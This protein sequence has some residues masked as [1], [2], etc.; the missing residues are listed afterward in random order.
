MNKEKLKISGIFISVVFLIWLLCTMAGC[1][2]STLIGK[3]IKENTTIKNPQVSC[4]Q[5]SIKKQSIFKHT[6]KYDNSYPPCLYVYITG[7]W[8]SLDD[9]SKESTLNAI[10]KYW[11]KCNPDN[12]AILTVMAYDSNMPV[13]AVF[14]S[15]EN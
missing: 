11:H 12:M 1:G 5:D 3:V 14:V 10:G 2:V 9:E 13:L 15:K 8:N 7:E 4:L 6:F